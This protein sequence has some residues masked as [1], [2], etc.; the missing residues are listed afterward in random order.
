[1]KQFIVLVASQLC[2]CVCIVTADEFCP[3]GFEKVEGFSD[4]CFYFHTSAADGK[5]KNVKFADALEICEGKNAMVFEPKSHEEGDLMYKFVKKKDNGNYAFWINYHDIQDQKFLIGVNYAVLLNSPYMGS[6]STFDKMPIEWWSDTW[7]K[8]G[9][10]DKG[11]HC[12]Y[13]WKTDGVRDGDCFFSK[14]TLVCET[15]ARPNLLKP[16]VS[17]THRDDVAT[18]ERYQ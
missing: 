4:R 8:G 2:L 10:R 3:P 11:E 17:K 7:N 16:R 5:Y 12:A 15:D 1:M 6:L 18:I 14:K 9:E 13:W